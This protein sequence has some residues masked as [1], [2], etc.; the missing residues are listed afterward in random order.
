MEFEKELKYIAGQKP[1]SENEL[2]AARNNRVRGYAQQF[3]S[4]GRVSGQIEQLW[5]V[6][7]PMSELQ[8]EPDELE[9]A[10]VQSV[11]AV[12]EKYATP[13]RATLLL[14]GDLSKIEPGIRELKL[15]DVVVLDAEG[16]PIAAT[17]H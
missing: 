9:K 6:G 2:T 3:E 10:S 5:A 11:N 15:G 8:R 12:A 4:M 14:V 13:G 7:L 16:Q 17:A 1:I